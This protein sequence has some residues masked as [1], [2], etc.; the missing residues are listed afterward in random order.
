MTKICIDGIDALSSL[1]PSED[2]LIEHIIE[3]TIFFEKEHVLEQASKICKML[4]QGLAIP[5][6]YTSNDPFYLRHPTRTTTPSFKNKTE[7]RKFTKNPAN[8]LYHRQT[9]IRVE[10][11]SD[12]NHAPK[13]AIFDC[14]KH[15]VSWGPISTVTNYTIAHIWNKTDNPL[16]F[17]LLWNYALLPMH[18]AFLTD[19]RDDSHPLIARVKELIRAISWELYNPNQIMKWSPDVIAQSDKP[20]ESMLNEARRLINAN[21]KK[22]SYLSFNDQ[23]GGSATAPKESSQVQ[24]STETITNE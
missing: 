17:S 21:P 18:C 11:D 12:G 24:E 3:H 16:Y 23:W 8:Y 13:L 4:E 22:I 15:R 1:F 20:S 2:A 6:R 9:N 7:A 5:V 19:K 14:T 10:T